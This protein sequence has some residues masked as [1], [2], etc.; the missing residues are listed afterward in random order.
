MSTKKAPA[1]KVTLQE[2][3]AAVKGVTFSVLPNGRTTVC[4][5]TCDNGFTV[6]GLSACVNIENY[7]Q[8]IGER[9]SRERA[10]NEL[11]GH[12]GFRLA[13]RQHQAKLRKARGARYRDSKSGTY[14]TAAFAKLNPDT[15]EKEA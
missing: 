3:E 14:V 1:A 4:Q 15:T 9:L 13:D 10:I 12:L 8:A 7:D 2:V 5:I 11:W 6:E